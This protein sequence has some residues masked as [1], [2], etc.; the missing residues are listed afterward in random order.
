[1]GLTN[2]IEEYFADI[3]QVYKEYYFMLINNNTD[4]Q[5]KKNV[6]SI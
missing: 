1:M 6:L 5:N 2:A 4:P 3:W